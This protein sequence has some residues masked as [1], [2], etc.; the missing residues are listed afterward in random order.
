MAKALEAAG[1]VGLL[2]FV[3][4]TGALW[5]VAVGVGARFL[6]AGAALTLGLEIGLGGTTLGLGRRG[7]NVA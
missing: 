2:E 4:V 6:R 5:D 1:F 3:G 7:L